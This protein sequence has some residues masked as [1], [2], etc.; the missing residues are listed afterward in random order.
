MAITKLS[1]ISSYINTIYE[2]ALFTARELN[3]MV[4]LVHGYSAQGFMART[5]PIYPAAT[6]VSVAD[7]A[8]YSNPT[9]MSKSTKATLT[10]GEVIAQALLTDQNMET[11]PEDEAANAAQE[12]GAA[13]STKIDTDLVGDFSSLAVDLGPGAGSAADLQSFADAIAYLRNAKARGAIQIVA[14]PYHWHDIWT[15]LGQ[16]AGTYDFLGDIANQAMRDYF[17][18]LFLGAR[19]YISANISVDDSDDAIS[20]IFVPDALAF[21]S[22]RPPRLEPERDASLRAT[23]LNMTAGYAHG[24]LRD[25]WGVYYTAD[26][27]SPS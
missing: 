16:P 27:T 25:E 17:V 14:H 13:I 2:D 8:D 7:G 6:A 19:W 20:G 1:S 18:G 3:L 21:D 12:L 11:S 22:R 9:T 10:P 23:E 15:Q 26:A 24:T 5:V 4:P